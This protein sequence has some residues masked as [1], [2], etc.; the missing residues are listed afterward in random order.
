[1]IY[2]GFVTKND[3]VAIHFKQENFVF[4]EG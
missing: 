3:W 2:Q 4:H 1:L